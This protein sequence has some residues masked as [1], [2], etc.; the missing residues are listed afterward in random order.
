M[1]YEGVPFRCRRRHKVG[2]IYK[3][4]PMLLKIVDPHGSPTPQKGKATTNQF[5]TLVSAPKD[6]NHGKSSKAV[7]IAPNLTIMVCDAALMA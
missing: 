7:V 2:H 5:R 4:C 3:E 6:H 1:D